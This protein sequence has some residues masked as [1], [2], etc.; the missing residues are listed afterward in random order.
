MFL[1]SFPMSYGN[2]CIPLV[3]LN[4]PFFVVNQLLGLGTIKMRHLHNQQ[5][6]V[7]LGKSLQIRGSNL[8]N[9]V[10]LEQAP[11]NSTIGGQAR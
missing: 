10:R 11:L 6:T 5:E 2:L 3:H 8:I 1:S 9:Y 4:P 7:Q